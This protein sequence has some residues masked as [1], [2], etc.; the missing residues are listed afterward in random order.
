MGIVCLDAVAASAGNVITYVWLLHLGKPVAVK[1]ALH[2]QPR[3]CGTYCGYEQ[4]LASITQCTTDIAICW[5]A[6]AMH[7]FKIH[8]DAPGGGGEGG[9]GGGIFYTL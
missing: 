4:M 2:G 1:S 6:Y 7:V 3:Q 5:I 9:R 8:Q